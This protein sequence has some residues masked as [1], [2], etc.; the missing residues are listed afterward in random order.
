VNHL[1]VID[2]LGMLDYT[3]ALEYEILHVSDELL[4]EIDPLGLLNYRCYYES[5]ELL[6]DPDKLLQEMDLLGLLDRRAHKMQINSK[7]KATC[8]RSKPHD[9][10][11]GIQRLGVL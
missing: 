2:L 8:A 9:A 3:T 1:N 7:Q 4:S 6:H 5:Y 11:Q 10:G